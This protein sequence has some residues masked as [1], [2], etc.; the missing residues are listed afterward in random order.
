MKEFMKGNYKIDKQPE[1]KEDKKKED[2]DKDKLRKE[3]MNSI[4]GSMV[5]VERTEL[6][7]DEDEEEECEE[8]EK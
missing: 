3:A 8:N 7:W 5:Y 4:G 1:E 2:T 6:V